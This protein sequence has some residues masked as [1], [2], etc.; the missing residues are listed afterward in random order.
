MV[1]GRMGERGLKGEEM[2]YRRRGGWK[3]ERV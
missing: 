1:G 3:C 2:E